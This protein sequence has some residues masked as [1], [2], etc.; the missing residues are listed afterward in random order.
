MP[1]M[2]TPSAA[3]WKDVQSWLSDALARASRR[4]NFTPDV[5]RYDA[6]VIYFQ[7]MAACHL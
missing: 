5:Q 3:E 4:I 7:I 1:E 6:E 2:F